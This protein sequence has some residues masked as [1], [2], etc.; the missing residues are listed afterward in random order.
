MTFQKTLLKKHDI[1]KNS[2]FCENTTLR[3][4]HSISQKNI[5]CYG[6]G[7]TNL[8]VASPWQQLNV[9][10]CLYCVL[11]P[12]SCVNV[13]L[14]LKR[15]KSR[16]WYHDSICLQSSH[17]IWGINVQRAV[18]IREKKPNRMMQ[19]QAAAHYL[20]YYT[21]P[22]AA[23]GFQKQIE[24]YHICTITTSCVC[25]WCHVLFQLALRPQLVVCQKLD[26][27]LRNWRGTICHHINFEG[28]DKQMII[29]EINSADFHCWSKLKT[30]KKSRGSVWYESGILPWSA[31]PNVPP[32]STSY[33]AAVSM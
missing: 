16:W 33:R 31:S 10:S 23:A 25:V 8:L 2:T 13:K 29:L 9:I 18:S 21:V 6:K 24:S 15:W 32:L 19:D 1:S 17:D 30:V 20:V 11:Q 28:S 12:V 22:T 3:K 5:W 4:T 26:L 14:S 27:P 7:G